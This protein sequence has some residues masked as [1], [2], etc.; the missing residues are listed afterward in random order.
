[1]LIA[2]VA[3][4]LQHDV[5][6]A[7][8]QLASRPNGDDA[9]GDITLVAVPSRQAQSSWSPTGASEPRR[10]AG[11]AELSKPAL[12]PLTISIFWRRRFSRPAQTSG[13]V[14][15]RFHGLLMLSNVSGSTSDTFVPW[16]LVHQVDGQPRTSGAPHRRSAHRTGHQGRRVVSTRQ[17]GYMPVSSCPSSSRWVHN[18]T[19]MTPRPTRTAM[20]AKCMKTP[21]C[22]ASQ[23]VTRRHIKIRKSQLRAIERDEA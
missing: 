15:G 13:C 22:Q 14:S 23:N 20:Y 21:R 11:F 7:A 2:L 1:M 8:C 12:S 10:V 19:R 5:R 16:C 6:Q 18:R 17:R 4:W 9:R 3:N